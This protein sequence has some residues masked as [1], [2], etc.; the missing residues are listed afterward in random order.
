M[1]R[2]SSRH[3]LF[4]L[5]ATFASLSTTLLHAEVRLPSLF[6]DHMVIQNGRHVPVWG[7][8]SPG[9]EIT[10]K[11]ASQ[12]KTVKTG[13]DGKWKTAFD[14]FKTT[15]Y[16]QTLTV[17]SS[18]PG[19]LTITI[20][21]VLIGEVW[22]ASG[23]SN[24][25]FQFAR[26]VPPQ[27]ETDAANIPT[28]RMFTVERRPSRTPQEECK[29]VWVV[30]TP[31][32]VQTFSAVA[33]FFG[34]YLHEK[35]NVPVGLINSSV[36]GTDI[37][38]WTSEPP[39]LKN[40]ELKTNLDL[41]KRN[42]AAYDPIKA[43]EAADK[44]IAAWKAKVAAAKA[45][46]T[47]PL[48]AKPRPTGGRPSESPNHPANLFNGMIAP[49]IPYAMRGAIWYQGEHNTATEEKAL[50]YKEQLPML[51][52]DWRARWNDDFPFA[53]VQLPNL[54]R[55]DY[56]P[57]VREA[58]FK[59]LSVPKTGMAVTVD[60][61]EPTDNHP[62]NKLDVGKR[63]SWWALRT[64]YD[65]QVPAASGPLFKSQSIKGKEIALSFTD[66]DGGLQAKG[67]S[68]LKGFLI[69][70]ADQK[71]KA[72]Q[73][74]IDGDTVLVSS[75][76]IAEP[77]AVRYSWASNPDGNLYNGPGLPASPFRTDDFPH[78]LGPER[79]LAIIDLSNDESRRVVIA[80]GTDEI[81]QGHPTTALLPD[82]KTMFAVWTLGHGGFAGPMKRS[83]DGG[84]TWSE[85]LPT[86]E[87]WK[88][89][90]NCP[91]IYRLTDPQGRSRLFVF[92]GQGKDKLMQQSVS[93]DDGKTW[94]PMKSNGLE[95]VMP[96]C[97]I[98]PI[99]D[100]KKLLAQTNIRRPGE[101]K[102]RTSN[103]IAQSESI[104]GGLTWS[105]FRIILDLGEQKP[106]E[107]WLIRSADGKQ[108]L[109][110][111]RENTR[112]INGYSMTSNDEGHTWSQPKPL[113]VALQGDRHVAKATPDGRLVICFRDTGK[114]SPTRTH[115]VAWVGTYED[116]IQGKQGEYKIKLAHSYA[117]G[118]CGYPGLEL[119]PDGTFA[120]TTYIKYREGPE[121]QSVISIR[122]K[123]DEIEKLQRAK[124]VP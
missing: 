75:P 61:G 106:C 29:G 77:V 116:I 12:T 118:D 45:A 65:Q 50:L 98:I 109:S 4:T 72:A 107:P 2:P 31:Q 56:R 87:N 91:S 101:T 48:P 33:Y 35:L 17:Q 120:A 36:G 64:V 97:T 80:Q 113:P 93:E 108:L 10:L 71:W 66:T 46:G 40:V 32:S 112:K 58:M 76:D 94:S 110:I 60:I 28:L 44:E 102:D 55:V 90:K 89:V 79:P 39:Q 19:S 68:G 117:G 57:L 119:L 7:W 104:D 53:W 41:W 9:E 111:M 37:A 96:F 86:P 67:G 54:D 6:S 8:A 82:G 85:L 100:G 22:L 20:Q 25:A 88:E 123:L 114:G 3:F 30:C 63:L 78:G 23:Q 27:A 13:V 83:N 84:K 24:M 105:P 21:D 14:Q 81:Y 124:Q 122:F 62:K 38:A 43:K 70:G 34:K 15:S 52:A 11:L 99:E 115:F 16:P 5:V 59:S 73:A 51:I 92:A 74:R 49:L 121:K 26:S 95:C 42:E 47:T 69:S 103:I 18:S 1:T